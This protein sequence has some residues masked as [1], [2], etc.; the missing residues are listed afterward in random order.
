MTPS[1]RLHTQQRLA[2][3]YGLTVSTNEVFL[4][5]KRIAHGGATLISKQS[6][7]VMQCWLI[8]EGVALRLVYDR[9]QRSILT[10]LPAEDSAAF[11]AMKADVE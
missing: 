1:Q 9:K 6:K 5:A 11:L 2:E 7:Q 4:M 8:H 10:A 3:R